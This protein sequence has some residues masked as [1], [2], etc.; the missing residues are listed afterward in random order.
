MFWESASL[1]AW[2]AVYP[3]LLP[4][5]DYMVDWTFPFLIIR[6]FWVLIFSNDI[7]GK[8]LPSFGAVHRQIWPYLIQLIDSISSLLQDKFVFIYYIDVFIYYILEKRDTWSTSNIVPW[9]HYGDKLEDTLLFSWFKIWCLSVCVCLYI[10]HIK[11]E[12][13][14]AS[15]KCYCGSQWLTLMESR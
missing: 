3:W 7:H 11:T 13:R 10:E 1:L 6:M 15:N 9:N 12:S 8:F 5:F 4:H 14:Q 2:W